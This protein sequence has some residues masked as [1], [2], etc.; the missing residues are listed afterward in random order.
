MDKLLEK[1]KHEATKMKREAKKLA[2][3]E[4][5]LERN[6]REAMSDKHY[7][8]ANSVMYEIAVACNNYADRQKV[9]NRAWEKLQSTPDRWCRILKT[10]VLLENLLKN[11]P[12]QMAGELQCEQ[13]HIRKVLHLSYME[14]GKD[15]G[16]AVRDKAK[17]VMDL[18]QDKNLLRD[19]REKAKQHRIKMGGGS[20]SAQ[21]GFGDGPA[22]RQGA[23]GQSQNVSRQSFD[24]RFNELKR[25][26]EQERAAKERGVAVR[27]K[28]EDPKKDSDD[29]R[30][31]R[32]QARRNGR[33]ER[34]G[35]DSPR[36]GRRRDSPSPARGRRRDDNSDSD[37]DERPRRRRN[38]PDEK[39]SDSGY[40]L[41]DPG[42]ADNAQSKQAASSA[43]AAPVD[44]LDFMDGPSAAG[45]AAS[46]QQEDWANFASAT[47]AA[48]NL[49]DV[50]NAPPSAAQPPD[51]FGDASFQAAAGAVP[52]M[53]P[54]LPTAAG[55]SD[56]F[57]DSAF[58]SAPGPSPATAAVFQ[59]SG[60]GM[61]PAPSANIS[62]QPGNPFAA[63]PGMQTGVEFSSFSGAQPMQQT[64]PPVIGGY[65]AVPGGA[66]M[67]SVPPVAMAQPSS[68]V[69]SAPA[70]AAV[71][72]KEPEQVNVSPEDLAKKLCDFDL[73]S[74]TKPSV[75]K[76]SEA[77]SF[78][79]L[80][81]L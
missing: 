16:E 43:S 48:P 70:S 59:L 17:S 33:D 49:F 32:D 34:N 4:T 37:R 28:H 71:R 76:T 66:G 2:E 8:C 45:P 23:A 6:M 10:L 30:K 5:Q 51:L 44:L 63:G 61:L 12:E 50:D 47:P 73:S 25:K 58:Q 22:S 55:N 3:M 15:R 79:D 69:S 80:P 56:F 21:D 11:G 24:D 68:S 26:Q 75:E 36:D 39:P 52:P 78:R 42:S 72:P 64:P 81:S 41:F 46:S 29:D 35:S 74:D 18:L 53:Q 40:A 54:T 67:S 60:P 1:A 27:D 14:E 19:E 13:N 7:G 31:H 38:S 20:S 57:G 77:D 65:P 62:P 9:L